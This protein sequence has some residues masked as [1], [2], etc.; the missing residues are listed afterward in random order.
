MN[1]MPRLFHKGETRIKLV[2]WRKNHF[3]DFFF[4][5]LYLDYF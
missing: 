5:V 3:F 2:L 4:I 1:H